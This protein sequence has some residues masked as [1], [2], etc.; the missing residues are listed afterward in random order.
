MKILMSRP[1]TLRAAALSLMAAVLI[2]GLPIS[3]SA[4]LGADI[5]ANGSDGPVTITNGDSFTYS[6]SS[7]NATACTLT[8]PT[9]DSEIGR[10][11]V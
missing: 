1:K 2:S 5:K 10:A 3:A 6:W 9:G 8:S 4:A 11:H 7:S